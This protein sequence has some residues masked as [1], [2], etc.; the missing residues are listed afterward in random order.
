[1]NCFLLAA[2]LG[3]R[4]KPLTNSIPKCLVDINNKPLLLI[5]LDNLFSNGIDH[6]FINTHYLSHKIEEVIDNY[7]YKNCV[8]LIYEKSLLGT[9]G[10]IK[11]NKNLLQS[12]KLLIAHADNL[13]E[14]NL[15]TFIKESMK[16]PDFCDTTLL[17][18]PTKNAK[19]EGVVTL[20]D[21][22]IV[23]KWHEKSLQSGVW[24]SG[25]TFILYE[26]ILNLIYSYEKKEFDLSKDIISKNIGKIFAVKSKGFFSDVGNLENLNL[27]RDFFKK[28]YNI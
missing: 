24:S 13:I 5:W 10:T 8:S 12:N 27:A 19:D 6:V 3:T 21:N 18:F 4:L 17:V 15:S 11:K 9:G 26:K 14:M 25:A 28:K 2:G 23:T 1:M 20:D 22:N 7:K 16:K